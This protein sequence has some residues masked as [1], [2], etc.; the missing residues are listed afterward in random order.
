ML[1]EKLKLKAIRC[2]LADILLRQLLEKGTVDHA[3]STKG[4]SILLLLWKKDTSNF[5]TTIL[6]LLKLYRKTN[7]RWCF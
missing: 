7:T 3:L 4:K 6:H 5:I 1:A 2:P